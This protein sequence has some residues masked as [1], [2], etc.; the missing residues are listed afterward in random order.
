MTA[1]GMS[2]PLFF[3]DVVVDS[4]THRPQNESDHDQLSLAFFE[5]ANVHLVG[6]RLDAKQLRRNHNS[7]TPVSII[8]KQ[9]PSACGQHTGGIVWETSYLLIN[10]FLSQKCRLGKTL[11][12]GAGCG[13]LGQVLAASGWAEKVVLTETVNVMNNLLE[14]IQRNQPMVKRADG[15]QLDWMNV[16]RD[17]NKA[18]LKAHSFDTIVGADVIFTPS[19]VEPLLT[20]LRYMS[21]EDTVVYL[22]LQVRCPDSHRLLLDKARLYE[23]VTKDV[24]SELSLIPECAW[25]LHMDIILLR[26]TKIP[27]KASA[28][29]HNDKKRKSRSADKKKKRTKR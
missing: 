8:V 3:Q 28:I 26:L 29:E 11:E 7:I 12:V 21:H 4:P 10:Y 15:R 25:G 13:L 19:L 16:E 1:R 20:T 18:N 23:W 22:C 9:D 14:N 5:L 2:E 6:Y 17:A 27:K 24:S